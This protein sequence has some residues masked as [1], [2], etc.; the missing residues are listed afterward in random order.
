MRLLR[1]RETEEMIS[2]QKTGAGE[3]VNLFYMSLVDEGGNKL[4]G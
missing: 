4:Q 1:K 2:T 3:E